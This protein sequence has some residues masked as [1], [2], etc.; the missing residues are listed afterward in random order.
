MDDDDVQDIS[1]IADDGAAAAAAA[2]KTSAVSNTSS[3]STSHAI[4]STP[5]TQL[6]AKNGSTNAVPP[7]PPRPLT[8]TQK[9]EMIL[10]E[11][12][13]SVDNAV[14]K[15]VLRASG[16]KVEP[17]FNAL[18]GKSAYLNYAPIPYA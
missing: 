7:K 2:A 3:T 15:A 9:N 6:N 17:A 11:A 13:P 12:F 4:A 16:G 18:L 5:G 10:K 14:I 8:E 1:I